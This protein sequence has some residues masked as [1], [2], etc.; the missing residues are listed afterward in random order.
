MFS[1]VQLSQ[2]MA[3]D[4][5]VANPIRTPSDSVVAYRN[6]ELYCS[7]AK[8]VGTIT[9]ITADGMAVKYDNGSEEKF[10]LGYEVGKGA[11]EYHKHLKITDMKV[12]DKVEKGDVLAWDDCFYKGFN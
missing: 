6:S 2:W 11:G 12:G 4:S 7:Y 3:T 1:G 9:A 10:P 8:E 5:Y